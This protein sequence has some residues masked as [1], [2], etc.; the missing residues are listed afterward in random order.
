MCYAHN[1]DFE[2]IAA[3]MMEADGILIGSPVYVLGVPSKLRALMERTGGF[4]A[5]S[6]NEASGKLRFKAFGAIVVAAGRRAGQD[7]TATELFNWAFCMGMSIIP[8]FPTANGLPAASIHIGSA[9]YQHGCDRDRYQGDASPGIS[10]RCAP[11]ECHQHGGFRAH[12]PGR[13]SQPDPGGTGYF[14]R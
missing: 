2:S 10:G 9:D 13:T 1:D 5:N 7:Q 4:T 11:V 14:R 12:L 6:M 8:A 3:S